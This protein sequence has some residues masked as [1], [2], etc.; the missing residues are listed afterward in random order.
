MAHSGGLDSTCLTMLLAALLRSGDVGSL[1]VAHVDHGLRKCSA[2][3][4]KAS[5]QLAQTL[6]VK[7]HLVT[8]GPEDFPGGGNIQATARGH[9]RSALVA[10]AK[11]EGL[12]AIALAHHADDQ[13]ETVLFRIL[14]GAGAKGAAGMDEWS[15]PYIRPLLE[16]RRADLEALAHA[17]GW[18]FVTDP[19]NVSDKYTRNRI[20]NELLGLARDIVP[21][22][23][24]ALVRFA[25]LIG[26]DDRF[27]SSLARRELDRLCVAEPE[28]LSLPVTGLA[29]LEPPIRR[30]LLLAALEKVGEKSTPVELMHLEQIEALLKEGGTGKE[31]PI[32]GEV[33]AVRT[34]TRLWMVSRRAINSAVPVL[35]RLGETAGII[36]ADAGKM[37]PPGALVAKLE[38]GVE[39]GAV[40][41]SPKAPGDRLVVRAK[42]RKVKDLL[43]KE[44]LPAWRRKLTI[45]ARSRDRVV[46]AFAPNRVFSS[47]EAVKE[48]EGD[49]Q[50]CALLWVAGDWWL[51]GLD[52][53]QTPA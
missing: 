45:V 4:A 30:R 24:G 11:K 34:A 33:A 15:P 21:G 46:A 39:L 26:E 10:L 12:D 32:P 41:F 1:H 19:T 22:A 44:G 53:S 38:P 48:G 18:P 20:R 16:V 3:D 40:T 7:F 8:L 27:L 51:S 42:E 50:R 23:D 13:A 25:G 35:P 29:R 28:G 47:L 2:T 9:R 5:R 36:P 17:L 52:I 37:P 49:G 14:R 43:M 6:G 31:A